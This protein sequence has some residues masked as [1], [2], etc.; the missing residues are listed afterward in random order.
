MNYEERLRNVSVLGAAGKMG[1]GILLL[2]AVEMADLSLKPENK[3]K[4]FVLHAIDVSHEA[5]SGVMKYLRSQVLKIAEKKIV[6]LRAFYQDHP[7]LIENSEIID[8][9]IFDVLAIVRP[10]T[11]LEAAY[12]SGLVFE[13]IR[14]DP[15]LKVKIFSQINKNNDNLPW[16][17]TNTSSIPITELDEKT[18]LEGRIIGF[19]FYNPPAI[20]KLVELIKAKNTQKELEEFALAYAKNLRKVVVPSNDIA[21]FIGNGHFMRDILYAISQ[22]DVLQKETS[23]VE[24]VYAINKISHEYL[25][26]PMGIF[27]LIDYVGVDVCSYILSVMNSHLENEDL[28]CPLLQKYLEPGVKGGQYADGS[29]KDGFLKYEKGRITGVYDPGKKE[30]VKIPSIEEKVT[31][32]LGA[33]P[34]VLPWKSVVGNPEK[35]EVLRSYFKEIKDSASTGAKLTLSYALKSR[36]IGLHL[37][38]TKV[39]QNEKDVNTV[40][41]TGFYH[42]YGPVNDYVL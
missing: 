29:Q 13:A 14:E 22:V 7:D 3:E 34:A 16:F 31:K 2:T 32:M 8:Q 1:S 42:A 40:L 19:H 5:L 26:R 37:V 20:Q 36:E 33:M 41:L 30:Y 28:S 9:Y 18:G 38:N 39:A 24:A 15:E 4:S 27:Q 11:R 21:G 35:E 17:F 6:A 10:T 12:E 23:F 25:I